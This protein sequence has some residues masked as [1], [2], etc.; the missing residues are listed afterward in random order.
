M[1]CNYYNAKDD[2]KAEGCC[3]CSKFVGP[4]CLEYLE[5]V[6]RDKVR[7]LLEEFGW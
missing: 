5:R 4:E 7:R 6:K 1:N 2:T 3:N